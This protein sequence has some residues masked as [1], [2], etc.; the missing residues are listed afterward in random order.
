MMSKQEIPGKFCSEKNNFE[1]WSV[2]KKKK[3][4]GFE[5]MDFEEENIV[6]ETE[7]FKEKL[8]F[9]HTNYLQ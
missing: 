9:E 5:N 4:Q 7:C 1:K 6:L 3:L 2:L 8:M